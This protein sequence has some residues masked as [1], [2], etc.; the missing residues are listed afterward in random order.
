MPNNPISTPEFTPFSSGCGL[1]KPSTDYYSQQYGGIGNYSEDG[2]IPQSNGK[3]LFKA[4]NF[5][6]P[7]NKTFVKNNYGIDYRT[8][9]GGS[10]KKSKKL[11]GGTAQSGA[12]PMNQRFYDPDAHIDNSP[13]LS[14]KGVMS[15]YGPIDPKDVGTG[16]LA[17]YTTSSCTTA[18]YNTNMKTGGRKNK[19]MKGKG[20]IPYISSDGVDEVDNLVDNAISNFTGFLQTLDQDYVKSAQ[21]VESIKIGNQRLIR[22]G[23]LDVLKK[24]IK[25]NIKMDIKKDILKKDVKKDVK[26]DIKKDILKKDVK[27]DIKKDIKKDVLKKDIKKDV[28]KKDIKKDIKKDVLKKDIKKDIKKRV[29]NNKN[30]G[31]I[32]SDFALTLN[33][34]GPANAPDDFWGVPGEEWFRQFNKTGQYIPNSQLQFAATPLLAGKGNSDVVTGYSEPDLN[35]S[36][37]Y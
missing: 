16:L 5:D 35:Y 30:G 24:D 21:I 3:N 15:A 27:K 23:K 12:T 34:R 7:L 25:K 26:K 37:R 14:G 18:N 19:N 8:S 1:C 22:G 32:G 17:P 6:L 28:L 29:K 20:L 2:L 9:F 33:S 36:F 11:K 10:N 31:S 13:S 4:R